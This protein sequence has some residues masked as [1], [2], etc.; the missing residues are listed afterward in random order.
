MLRAMIDALITFWPYLTAGTVLA[1]ALAA[2]GHAIIYKRDSRAAVGWVGL[3]WL[4]PLL[5]AVLYLL[6]GINR[7]R[8][9]VSGL[10]GDERRHINSFEGH[11]ITEQELADALPAGHAHLAEIARL[12]ARLT[13]FELLKGNAVEPLINGDTAYPAMLAAIEK[14]ERS[15]ALTTYIFDNDATGLQFV[16]ALSAAA[17]RG[18]E[19]RVLID[20][21]G[22]RYS[23]PPVTQRLRAQGVR[24]ARFMPSP[25]PWVNPYINLRSHRK[26][27]VVDGRH[28]F[29]GGLNIRHNNRLQASPRHPTRDIHFR[30][31]GPVVHEM[32]ATFAEDWLF[33]T[34]ETL[35]GPVWFPSIQTAGPVLARAIPDGPDRDYDK[36][37]MAFHGALSAAQHEVRIVTPYFLPDAALITALNTC[38][39]RGVTVDIVLPA[40]NNLKL[41]AWASMAQMWQILEWGCRVW[42]TPEPFDHGKLLVVDRAWSLIGSSNWDPRSLRL[43]FEFGLECYDRNLAGQLHALAQTK[44]DEAKPLLLAEVNGRLL[45]IKLRDGIARLFAPYL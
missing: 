15:I 35:A 1:L 44:I 31:A 28:G 30:V 36:M 19:V 18:V 10:R 45:P 16:E 4:A 32:Q 37:R 41:V 43:N 22:A 39:M 5:G 17:Q 2:S 8:R 33:T 25:L 34:G 13:Q 14:A 42:L 6:L 20:A 11:A 24:T 38:A 7:V 3:I 23:L 9:R 21:V 27:L 29:T 12:N 40:H 26:I